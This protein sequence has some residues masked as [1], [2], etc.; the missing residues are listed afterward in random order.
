[1]RER[2]T[3]VTGGTGALGRGVVP[4]LLARGDRVTVPWHSEREI[5]ALREAVDG[6]ERLT[7]VEG[8]VTD[9]DSVDAIMEGMREAHGRLDVVCNLV[10]GFSMGALEDTAPRVWE[11]MIGLNARSVFLVTRA[12]LPLLRES[13]AARVVNI[14]ALPAVERGAAKMAAYAAAKAAVVS[15]THSLSAELVA[16]GITV[17]AVAP[18][19]LDTEANREAMSDADRSTWL[20]PQEVAAVLDFLTGPDA[21]IVTGSVLTLR[22]S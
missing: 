6:D 16:E 7:L 3:L 20:Q 9:P 11:R 8:D 15:L 13:D 5:A 18:S 22:R 19:I 21:G 12:A 17:N 1:M 10:G 14:A 4:R 2:I